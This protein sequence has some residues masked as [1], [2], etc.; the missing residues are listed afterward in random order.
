MFLKILC[1]NNDDLLRILNK[2]IQ[3]IPGVARTETFITPDQPIDKQV[4]LK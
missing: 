4:P 2:S 3:Q 1:E